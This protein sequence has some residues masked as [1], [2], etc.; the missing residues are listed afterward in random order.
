MLGADNYSNDNLWNVALCWLEQ[1]STQ[2]IGCTL[3]S[4]YLELREKHLRSS[5]QNWVFYRL[6][7]LFIGKRLFCGQLLRRQ[8]VTSR[9][10]WSTRYDSYPLVPYTGRGDLLT[11]HN[12]TVWGFRQEIES[13]RRFVVGLSF[14]QRH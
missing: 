9:H 13:A 8:P 2:Y 6:V 4:I 7:R 11:F 12:L 1:D 3:S 14:V 10:R 5:L